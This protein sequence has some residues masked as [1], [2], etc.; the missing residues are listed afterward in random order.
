MTDMYQCRQCGT[1]WVKHPPRKEGEVHTW[2]LATPNEHPSPC[3]DNS[4]DF[5][6]NID[7]VGRA[8]NGYVGV[9][10]AV[11]ESV[12]KTD[13]FRHESFI[14]LARQVLWLRAAYTKALMRAEKAEATL[15]GFD[16]PELLKA[17]ADVLERALR[18]CFQLAR[19]MFIKTGTRDTVQWGHIMR[20]C[21][22]V[23]M[24]EDGVCRQHRG[25]D[26]GVPLELEGQK[27]AG[28]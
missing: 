26:D 23:G 13:D 27:G 12:L 15:A 25:L 16:N 18:N 10:D 19:R 6:A 14:S 1:F 20:F 3:C 9:S 7:K 17:R 21:K 11:I 8:P 24:E 2:S 5:L 28:Q 4:P 22:E